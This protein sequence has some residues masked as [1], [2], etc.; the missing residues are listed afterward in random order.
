[1][2]AKLELDVLGVARK[3]ANGYGLS[4]EAKHF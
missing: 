3:L 1:M 2:H 4:M